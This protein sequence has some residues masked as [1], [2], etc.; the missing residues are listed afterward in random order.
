MKHAVAKRVIA[1]TL[2]VTTALQN[3]ATIAMAEQGDPAIVDSGTPVLVD[4]PADVT[5]NDAGVP[6]APQATQPEYVEYVPLQQNQDGQNVDY[7][8]QEHDA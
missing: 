6:A 4:A 8:L 3:P 2:V 1:L 5:T 7:L